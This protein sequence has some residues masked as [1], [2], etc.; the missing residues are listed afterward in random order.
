MPNPPQSTVEWPPLPVKLKILFVDD[1]Q[2]L[3]KLFTRIINN[4]AVELKTAL[5]GLEALTILETFPADVVIT[6]VKMPH[7]DGMELLKKIQEHY[8]D[9][10]TILITG[11]SNVPDAVTSIKTGAYDYLS[12]PFDFKEIRALI[13]NIAHHK[14]LLE[15][16]Y[17]DVNT[18]NDRRK[19]HRF[20]NIIG[21]DRGMFEIFK[22]IQ[23]VAPTDATV[24][25]TGETGAGKELV[26]KAI[27]YKSLRKDQP[28]LALN[29]GTV[30][31]SLMGSELF[32]HEKGA[33]TGAATMKKGYFEM[34]DKGTLFLD[35]IGDVPLPVQVSLLRLLEEGTFQRV[36]STRTIKVDVRIVCATNKALQDLVHE[37][38]FREDLFYRLNVV[39]IHLPP[40]RERPLDIPVLVN[41]FIKKYAKKLNKNISAISRSAMEKLKTYQWPGNVR[42]LTNVI[43]FIVIFCKGRKIDEKD[44]PALFQTASSS[45]S[46]NFNIQ[47]KS[48]SIS[49]AESTLI[50]TVLTETG[51]N[52]KQSAELLEIA[53]GTLYSKIKKYGLKKQ[54]E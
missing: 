33:F 12:K 50:Q 21:R 20:E 29:C 2:S 47:L 30:S 6:D 37:N 41:H 46:D 19:N 53:R 40:L 45:E 10:F 1:E 3:H 42:E 49:R 22:K 23:D 26:A 36:G 52:L 35:E 13:E 24:L 15:D 18:T 9:T 39:P 51:W 28:F 25:I 8:P 48:R 43:E 17:L 27:H 14:D 54:E 4:S 32:G 34:A 38:R 16:E 11:Y 7:M 31:E 5:N 44:L